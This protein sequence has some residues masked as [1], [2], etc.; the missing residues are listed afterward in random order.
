MIRMMALSITRRQ[1]TV[2]LGLIGILIAV[3]AANAADLII[4]NPTNSVPRGLYYAVSPEHA[5]YVSFCLDHRHRD[6][7]Y[8]KRFCSDE[9]PY[10]I[11]ILKRIAERRPDGSLI[12]RGDSPTALDSRIL[13]PVQP[14]QIRAW[15]QPLIQI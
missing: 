3:W 4:G 9:R 13:G 1:R 8:Y 11:R 14:E 10:G 2:M 7:V 15:W 6:R 12:V 5:D